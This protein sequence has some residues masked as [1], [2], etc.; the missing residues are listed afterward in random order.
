M[1]TNNLDEA[2]REY[3]REVAFDSEALQRCLDQA[4]HRPFRLRVIWTSA[5]AVLLMVSS[6]FLISAVVR[7]RPSH[8]RQ[9][10][11]EVWTHHVAAKPVDVMEQSLEALGGRMPRL[12]FRLRSSARID[13][14]ETLG[15]R[16]CSLEGQLAAQVALR[17]GEGRPHTLYVTAYTRRFAEVS[18][19]VVE[20][21]RG[22]VHIW[23]EGDLIYALAWGGEP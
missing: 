22:Q 8:L 1:P 3:Y 15:A 6:A 10:A 4:S 14:L 19:A 21:D 20:L 7:E 23:R 2:V 11:A 18:D 16:Y 5:A 12:D 9:L 13:D 17:D